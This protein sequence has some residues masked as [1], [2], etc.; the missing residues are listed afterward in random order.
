MRRRAPLVTID[1]NAT[2]CGVGGPRL[3]KGAASAFGR[4]PADCDRQ[5]RSAGGTGRLPEWLEGLLELAGQGPGGVP[6]AGR[7]DE[8][9]VVAPGPALEIDVA[10]MDP[11][12]VADRLVLEHHR[13]L[14]AGVGLVLGVADLAEAGEVAPRPGPVVPRGLG[15]QCRR[16]LGADG[17]HPP[18]PALLLDH[19][20]VVALAGSD[21]ERGWDAH[22]AAA[23]PV[24]EDPPASRQPTSG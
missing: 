22:A 16:G 11:A 13:A 2:G 8:L 7:G 10:D 15:Q 14:V 9:D 21:P 23:G 1:R 12:A 6:V 5:V 20:G 17:E 19:G 24:G 18:G 3:D 4:R